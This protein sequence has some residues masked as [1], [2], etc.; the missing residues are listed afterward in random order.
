MV[1]FP[2]QSWLFPQFFIQ[3]Q[4]RTFC[5][6]WHQAPDYSLVWC[7][8][9]SVCQGFHKFSRPYHLRPYKQ[10]QM[11]ICLKLK[12]KFTFLLCTNFNVGDNTWE[13]VPCDV[14]KVWALWTWPYYE[15]TNRRVLY[16]L[17][18]RAN[19]QV[20]ELSMTNF[21]ELCF[22]WAWRWILS[23]FNHWFI[24]FLKVKPFQID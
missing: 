14:Q 20:F 23:D 12:L 15:I 10:G 24:F 11:W 17:N 8:R 18:C 1:P 6:W 4:P 13:K 21:S 2:S 9:Q 3:A 7:I 5:C 16:Q 22:H 19:S